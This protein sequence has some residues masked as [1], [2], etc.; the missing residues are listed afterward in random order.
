[1]VGRGLIQERNINI[2]ETVE[3]G[4]SCRNFPAGTIFPDENGDANGK[5]H[6]HHTTVSSYRYYS[7]EQLNQVINVTLTS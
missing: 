4:V 5:L 2:G 6:P 1:V 7:D 3:F